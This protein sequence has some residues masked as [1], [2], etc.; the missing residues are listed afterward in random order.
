MANRWSEDT[1]VKFVLLYREH[2]CLWNIKSQLY[3]NKHAR[4]AALLN[5]VAEMA[6]ST[7]KVSDA[8]L[9]I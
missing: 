7:F 2:D 8:K 4:E 6:I 9:K 1:T 3:R 5:I